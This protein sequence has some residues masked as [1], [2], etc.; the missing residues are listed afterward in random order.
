[1]AKALAESYMLYYG[2]ITL[3]GTVPF[4]VHERVAAERNLGN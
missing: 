2:N 4:Q 3:L 1:M